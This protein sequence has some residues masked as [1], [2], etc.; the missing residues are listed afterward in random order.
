VSESNLFLDNVERG[1]FL[2]N[3]QDAASCGSQAGNQIGIGLS[4]AGLGRCWRPCPKCCSHSISTLAPA[5][6]ASMPSTEPFPAQF[7]NNDFHND[8]FL[9]T[10]AVFRS[11]IPAEFAEIILLPSSPGLFRMLQTC[12]CVGPYYRIAPG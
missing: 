11:A 4:L 10:C 2:S 1:F 8:D 7:D 6:L 12:R 5:P 9:L 3:K